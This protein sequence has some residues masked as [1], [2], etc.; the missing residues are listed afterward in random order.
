MRGARALG[1]I[2]LATASIASA[3]SYDFDAFAPPGGDGGNETGGPVTPGE[4]G[5]PPGTDGSVTSDGSTTPGEDAV[6]PP[7]DGSTTEGGPTDSAPP[8]DACT[9]SPPC[10]AAAT[11]CAQA[12]GA[13]G[14]T[15]EAACNNNKC[16]QDCRTAER[17]C[18]MGCKN[19]CITCAQ[20]AGCPAP[21]E[22]D[23]ASQS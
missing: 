13:T 22:C 23:T 6:S 12:C 2:A 15:C 17:D 20:N 10:I 14:T 18:R 1:L 7:A 5:S 3:C 19:T 9:P 4:D 11:S 16:R 8:V 21:A